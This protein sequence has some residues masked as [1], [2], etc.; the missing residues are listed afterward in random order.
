MHISLTSQFNA[1]VTKNVPVGLSPLWPVLE[2][3]AADDQQKAD[4]CGVV[5]GFIDYKME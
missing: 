1:K 5:Y 4:R 2:D 3:D